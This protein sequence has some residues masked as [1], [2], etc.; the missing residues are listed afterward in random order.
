[1]HNFSVIGMSTTIEALNLLGLS[2]ASGIKRLNLSVRA[3]K[4]SLNQYQS[5]NL[6]FVFQAYPFRVWFPT[7][8]AFRG[9]INASDLHSSLSHNIIDKEILIKALDDNRFVNGLDRDKYFFTA[10][11]RA[12]APV[13]VGFSSILVPV[14]DELNKRVHLPYGFS[15]S[16]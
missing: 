6:S 16:H 1:M 9:W 5:S 14:V 15:I 7:Q 4:L 12:E 8:P 3:I 2:C 11:V 10:P 13:F